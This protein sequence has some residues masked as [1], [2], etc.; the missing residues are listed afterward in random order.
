MDPLSANFPWRFLD[1]NLLEDLVF[2]LR[3]NHLR[4]LE[5]TEELYTLIYK[6]NQLT[7]GSV[8]GLKA[9]LASSSRKNSVSIK[10]K[11]LK[12]KIETKSW[13]VSFDGP[14]NRRKV[15]FYDRENRSRSKSQRQKFIDFWTEEIEQRYR[16]RRTW[17]VVGA[18]VMAEYYD[19]LLVFAA[20]FGELITQYT[21]EFQYSGNFLLYFPTEFLLMQIG[22]SILPAVA[23][24]IPLIRIDF[25]FEKSESIEKIHCSGFSI[26]SLLLSNF[27]AMLRIVL[28]PLSVLVYYNSIFLNIFPTLPHKFLSVFADVTPLE[29]V[30]TLLIILLAKLIASFFRV[31]GLEKRRLRKSR[32]RMRT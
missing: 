9:Q 11:N 7:A 12:F 8:G 21:W 28:I 22:Y 19:L 29:I 23:L 15:H 5:D 2:A 3:R 17:R 32:R 4:N 24:V 31:Q 13:G 10:A 30:I 18:S 27:S 25:E 16:S 26:R 6:S 14:V 1:L 20:I